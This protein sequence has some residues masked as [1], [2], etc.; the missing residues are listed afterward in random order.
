MFSVA[1][2]NRIEDDHKDQDRSISDLHFSPGDEKT[3]EL[4]EEFD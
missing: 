1:F 4:S 2:T 3:N